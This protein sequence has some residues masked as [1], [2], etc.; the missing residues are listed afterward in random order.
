MVSMP[1]ELDFPEDKINKNKNNQGRFFG[2][3][4]LELELEN[5]NTRTDGREHWVRGASWS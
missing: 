2:K 4:G 1:S 3:R 5:R